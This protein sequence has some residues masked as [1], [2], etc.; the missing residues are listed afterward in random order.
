MRPNDRAYAR[1]A[2]QVNSALAIA[3][4]TPDAVIRD[5]LEATWDVL[6]VSGFCWSRDRYAR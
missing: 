3:E 2:R 6:G 5:F 4:T 1:A